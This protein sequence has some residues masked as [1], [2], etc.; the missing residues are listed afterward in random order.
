MKR[1]T[2]SQLI[3][4][5]LAGLCNIV[6]STACLSFQ[7]TFVYL[8]AVGTIFI[9]ALF[10]PLIGMIPGAI[11]NL[12]LGITTDIYSLYFLPVQLILGYISGMV[13][14]KLHLSEHPSIWK[15]MVA[16]FFIALPAT[17][18]ASFISAKL[19][20]GVTSSGSSLLVQLLHKSGWNLVHSSIAVQI[21]TDYC[22]RLLSIFLVQYSIRHLPK[23]WLQRIES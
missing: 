22:D 14:K 23:Q 10:G 3:L 16:A 5:S 4:I 21:F 12:L 7:I 19:F 15:N 13:W 20:H 6:L 11:S 2:T 9:A 8:D 1:L 17:I 18:V